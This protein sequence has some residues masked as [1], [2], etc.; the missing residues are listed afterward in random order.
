MIISAVPLVQYGFWFVSGSINHCWIGVDEN[1]QKTYS[2]LQD[3]PGLPPVLHL[4][5][6]L[7]AML[8]KCDLLFE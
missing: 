1:A 4:A 8:G 3:L 6:Q 5:P 7:A 2:S